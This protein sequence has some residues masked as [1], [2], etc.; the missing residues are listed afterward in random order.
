MGIPGMGIPGM[1]IPGMGI[2]GMGPIGCP[3]A[4]RPESA[5]PPTPSSTPRLSIALT[6]LD[7]HRWR[8]SR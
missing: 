8:A 5:I 4:D 1:G 2:P 7:I 6:P 3:R